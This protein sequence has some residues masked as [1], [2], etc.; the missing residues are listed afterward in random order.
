MIQACRL[1]KSGKGGEDTTCRL[2]ITL[3][4]RTEIADETDD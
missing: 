1:V 3:P 4:T 2:W